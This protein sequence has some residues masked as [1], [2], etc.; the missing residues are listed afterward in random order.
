MVETLWFHGPIGLWP[1]V[2]KLVFSTKTFSVYRTKKCQAINWSKLGIAIT[3]EPT[4]FHEK[5]SISLLRTA[6][7]YWIRGGLS[8]NPIK[9]VKNCE[10][11]ID[12]YLKYLPIKHLPQNHALYSS[13]LY[14]LCR[15]LLIVFIISFS[16]PQL[17]INRKP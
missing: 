11:I 5:L 9:L 10:N 14:S 16:S 13:S 3:Q 8:Y 1:E 12:S 4:L 17:F 2:W 7:A 15:Q 6:I